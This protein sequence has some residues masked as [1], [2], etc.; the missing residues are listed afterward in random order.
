MR[1]ATKYV[2]AAAILLHASFGLGAET[3]NSI[4]QRSSRNGDTSLQTLESFADDADEVIEADLA[5]PMTEGAD[6]PPGVSSDT[7]PPTRASLD[8]SSGGDNDADPPPPWSETDFA[9]P[10][11][12]YDEGMPGVDFSA[13]Y[14][15]E[16]NCSCS[17]HKRHASWQPF[18]VRG[19]YV[20]WWFEGFDVPALV[21]S[22]PAS[23][24]QSEAGV[25][26]QPATSILFGSEALNQ[27]SASGGIAHVGFRLNR[28]P[29]L[30]VEGRLLSLAQLDNGFFGSSDGSTIL[31]RPFF[32][33]ETGEEDSSLI[34][35]PGLLSGEVAISAST[36]YDSA[37]L[38]L[39]HTLNSSYRHH[40]DLFAGCRYQRLEDG[41]RVNDLLT[42]LDPAA[43]IPVGSTIESFDHF[44]TSNEFFGGQLGI[45]YLTRQGC[46]SLELL[47]RLALGNTDADVNID[48]S[49]TTTT[50]GNSAS[51]AGGLLALP[52]NIG[53]YSADEFSI[54]PEISLDLRYRFDRQLEVSL[55]YSFLYWNEV[56]RPGD[57]IDRG[58]NLS[59]LPPG[60]F[61]GD[62]RP[63]FNFNFTDIWMQG[64]RCGLEFSF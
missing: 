45:S 4:P 51:Y 32:N 64:L 25:L 30:R 17:Q 10:V 61:M 38:I 29:D 20:H 15:N 12:P 23:T 27:D 52:T 58:L 57:Q 43:G 34:A 28:C 24:P 48:G 55:G 36:E 13:P 2:S 6:G 41:L 50:N 19:S 59:Q 40:V 62:E 7:A 11:F 42:S 33:I 63:E 56:A 53:R 46:W 1:F 44:D 49:T 47:A 16:P 21:T 35:Y 18:W 39:R 54:V 22:S 37:D 3:S 8:A 14:C 5:A 60:P 9:Q 26:G 31:A